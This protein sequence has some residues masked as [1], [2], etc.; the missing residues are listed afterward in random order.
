[1]LNSG[2][3]SSDLGN[4]SVAAEAYMGDTITA[5]GSTTGLNL[6]LNFAVNGSSS[7]DDPSQGLTFLS[8][9]I[10]Q[11]GTF[12][13]SPYLPGI[14][15]SRGFVLGAGT[16]DHT[17]YFTQFHLTYGGSY[18][19]GT[20]IIPIDIPFATIG[21]SFQLLVTLQS[22]VFG[23]SSTGTNWDADFGHTVTT[24]LAAPTGVSLTSGSGVLPGTTSDTP[25]PR[26][27]LLLGA[28]ILLLS[29]RRAMARSGT[30]ASR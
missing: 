27:A 18:G 7:Y 3:V 11:A 12:D 10:L 29:I 2:N 13:T 1:M 15:W 24:S 9:Y 5:H 8:V 28:G 17:S 6:G 23:D 30:A 14:L 16:L 25:E 4:L 19:N 22:Y 26:S 21:S 20:S